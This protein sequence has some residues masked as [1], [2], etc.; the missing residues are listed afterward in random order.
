MLRAFTFIFNRAL[1]NGFHAIRV[2]NLP[3]AA[4]FAAPRLVVFCNHPSWW[5]A[6]ILFV[7][8]RTFC[9]GRPSYA[10]IDA[11][12]I[13]RYGFMARIGAFGVEQGS[14]LGARQFREACR[15]ILADA[16]SALFITAQARFADCR[17]RPLRIAGGVAHIADLAPDATYLP[18]AIEYPHW[19]EKQPELLIR[20]GDPIDAKDLRGLSRPLRLE[21][22]EDALTETMDVLA[23]HAIA[24]EASAFQTIV[25]GR[26]GVNPIYDLW[27]RA[28]ATL[29]GQSFRASHG[30]PP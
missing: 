16:R 29:K 18:L 20:F 6:V 2:A 4:T 9:A 7:L 21:R 14:V 24:R 30:A 28:N 8:S 23:R 10:P 25:A 1:R 13:E 26:A 3:E 19:L 15:L 22:L 17:E 5:D 12:M 11:A 27:R